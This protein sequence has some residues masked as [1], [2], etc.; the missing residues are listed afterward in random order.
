MNIFFMYLV[1]RQYALGA[2]HQS[3]DLRVCGPG[4][5]SHHWAGGV[6]GLNLGGESDGDGVRGAANLQ[7]GWPGNSRRGRWEGSF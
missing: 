1:V 4:N 5:V 2:A 7:S 6:G 3:I